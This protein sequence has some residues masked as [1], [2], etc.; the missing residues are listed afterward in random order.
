MNPAKYFS[1]NPEHTSMLV[2]SSVADT[3]TQAHLL[4]HVFPA[5]A[6]W[7]SPRTQEVSGA[8]YPHGAAGPQEGTARQVSP[9]VS[10]PAP[11]LAM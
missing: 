2:C 1:P 8:A 9:P 7:G 4:G 10:L 5:G 11:T 6:P 3:Q